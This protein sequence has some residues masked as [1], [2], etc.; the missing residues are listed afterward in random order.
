MEQEQRYAFFGKRLYFLH[1]NL[2]KN[3]RVITICATGGCDAA[4]MPD[5]RLVRDATHTVSME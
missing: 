5:L 1:I 3:A 4:P 2:S